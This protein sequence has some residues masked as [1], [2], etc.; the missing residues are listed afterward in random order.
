MDDKFL[1]QIKDYKYLVDSLPLADN[2]QC[3]EHINPKNVSLT[4]Q[5]AATDFARSLLYRCHNRRPIR[6]C[7]PVH[8]SLLHHQH[9]LLFPLTSTSTS[10]YNKFTKYKPFLRKL[11]KIVA[12]Y[13]LDSADLQHVMAARVADMVDRVFESCL[14]IRYVAEC[15]ETDASP[16]DVVLAALK[17]NADEVLVKRVLKRVGRLV[18]EAK[19]DLSNGA[20]RE[21]LYMDDTDI[22]SHLQTPTVHDNDSSD[23]QPDSDSSSED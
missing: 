6:H 8:M 12:S 13:G 9:P 1:R 14:R 10:A 5:I 3:T 2:E 7:W 18:Q 15:K 21:Q 20:V 17:C 4:S 22:S 11:G 16:W 19:V 23:T